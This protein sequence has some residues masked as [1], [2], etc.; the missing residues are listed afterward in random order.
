MSKHTY[1]RRA[2]GCADCDVAVEGWAWDD[3]PAPRC[4][5]C[6]L[7]L[8]ET[9]PR[10]SPAPTVV[11]DACDVTIEHGICWPG[12]APRHYTSKAEMKREAWKRGLVNY[13]RHVPVPGSDKSP[14]TA[15]WDVGPPPGTDPRPMALLTPEEQAARRAEVGPR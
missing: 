13:V 10:S 9:R 2:W 14:F 12:G 6:L 4:P 5:Q 8:T 11:G 1:R 3:T 15:S 7:V